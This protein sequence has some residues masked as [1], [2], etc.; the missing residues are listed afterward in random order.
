MDMTKEE[1]QKKIDKL[2]KRKNRLKKFDFDVDLFVFRRNYISAHFLIEHF[3]EEENIS[4]D[5]E[6]TVSVYPQHWLFYLLLTLKTKNSNLYKKICKDFN[7]HE[8][9]VFNN[10]SEFPTRKTNPKHPIF[11][12]SQEDFTE[13]IAMSIEGLIK[14]TN[15]RRKLSKWL[16]DMRHDLMRE[17]KIRIVSMNEEI[18]LLKHS[19]SKTASS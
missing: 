17:R 10:S 1:I 7:T 19:K 16:S 11:I 6:F 4:W 18:N 13:I 9:E 14:N 8:D 12:L 15:L 5:R 3:H 2:E